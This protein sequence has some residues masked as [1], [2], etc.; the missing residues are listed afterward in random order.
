M[1]RVAR[2]LRRLDPWLYRYPF[3]GGSARRYATLE[4]RGFGD[5]DER[6]LTQWHPELAGAERFLDVGCGPATLSTLIASRYSHLQIIGAEPSREYTREH[7]RDVSLLRAR[8]EALPLATH[9]ID[10][11][12]CIS[13]IRHVRDRLAGLRELR[14]VVR[15]GG[16]AF[17]VELDPLADSARAQEHANKLGARILALAF[18]PLVLATGPTGETIMQTAREAGWRTVDRSDDPQ[19][20]VYVLRLR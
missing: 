12:A 13:S 4:R 17:I 3:E 11:A 9:S 15:P 20:P 18:A 2:L 5:L 1:N 6:L 19:Q 10:V 16:T 7:R 8:A 14:R